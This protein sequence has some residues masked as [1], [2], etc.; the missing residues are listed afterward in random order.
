MRVLDACAAPGGKAAHLLEYPGISLVALDQSAVRLQRLQ[1]NLV[2]LGVRARVQTGDAEQP[3]DW[4][5]GQMFDRVLLDAPCSATGVIRRHPDI[6]FLRQ[7][8]DVAKFAGQ[9]QR[10]LQ[11]LWPLLRPGGRLL[12]ATCSVLRAENEAVIAAFLAATSDAAEY[13]LETGPDFMGVHRCSHGLQLLPG[14]GDTD[15]FYYALIERVAGS[16][17]AGQA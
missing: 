1:D 6:R 9:Q 8:G 5:D 10:L 13:P 11:A 16:A 14:E 15:G 3:A 17:P 12:Y 2:R 4:W 7:P